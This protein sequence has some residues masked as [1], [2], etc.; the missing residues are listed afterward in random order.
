MKGIKA[1]THLLA[2]LRK[3]GVTCRG[4]R[5]HL[6]RQQTLPEALQE[7]NPARAPGPFVRAKAHCS[8]Q[9]GWLPV[10]RSVAVRLQHLS[11]PAWTCDKWSAPRRHAAVRC[12]QTAARLSV[13]SLLLEQ[14]WQLTGSTPNQLSTRGKRYKPLKS[15]EKSY[16]CQKCAYLTLWT[17]NHFL[18]ELWC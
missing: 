8:R 12:Q 14:Q 1:A 18:S 10:S 9:L 5:Q 11:V 7:R 6:C 15:C 16:A 2:I 4:Y 17:V 3:S 13:G